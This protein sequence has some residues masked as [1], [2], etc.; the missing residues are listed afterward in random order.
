MDACGWWTARQGFRTHW[1]R[2]NLI[3]KQPVIA[4]I[5]QKHVFT[6]KWHDNAIR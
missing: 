6:L 4:P 3:M 5:L 2:E 1:K